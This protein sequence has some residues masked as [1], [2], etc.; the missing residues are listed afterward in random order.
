M[1]FVI[2]NEVRNLF[3]PNVNQIFDIFRI[4]MDENTPLIQH[5][6]TPYEYLIYSLLH[7]QIVKLIHLIP[8]G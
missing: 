6:I 1:S 3:Q 5:S 4:D 7:W 8:F 2:S